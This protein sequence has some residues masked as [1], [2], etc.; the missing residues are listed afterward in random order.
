MTMP[1]QMTFAQIGTLYNAIS[2]QLEGGVSPANQQALLGQIATVQ[3]QINGLIKNGTFNGFVEGTGDAAS[4]VTLVHAQNIADQMSHLTKLVGTT[5]GT[6]VNSPPKYINDVVR[7]VQDIV[8]GDAN[9]TGLA[10]QNGHVGFQQVSNLLTPPTPFPDTPFQTQTLLKFVADAN[11]IAARGQALAGADPNSAPVQTLIQDA[12]TVAT[13]ISAYSQAQ[14]GVFAARFNNEFTGVI[15]G[16]TGGVHGTA[17]N[18]LVKGLQTGNAALVNGA[19]TVMM[20]NAGDVRGNMLATGDVFTPAPNFGIPAAI[21]DIHTAG[22]VYDDA[23]TKL[24]GGVDAVNKAGVVADLKATQT[25]IQNTIDHG[26]IPPAEMAHLTQLVS[27]LGHQGAL[28]AGIDT[29]NP[30]PISPVNTQIHNDTTQILNIVQNDAAITKAADGTFVPLPFDG[31]GNGLIADGYGHGNGHRATP[32]TPAVHPGH[33][34]PATP[35]I[36]AMPAVS[37][38][39][40]LAHMA[41]NTPAPA[42]IPPM[43]VPPMPTPV[44]APASMPG[45]TDTGH[46]MVQH[47][48]YIH[49]HLV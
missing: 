40:D 7:D 12:Q 38:L 6:F 30:T 47:H 42:P 49:D 35:A 23:V 43:P 17:T 11:D 34:T 29:A 15:Q 39:P 16:Q 22:M 27:L 36:P 2:N 45:L 13:N 5:Y 20:A 28:V 18:E 37:P 46:H 4:N 19:A 14:G 33:G 32:A 3:N 31:P 9:L 44:N 1:K 10:T 41:V 48:I 25:G 8:A 24:I 21:P 26:G